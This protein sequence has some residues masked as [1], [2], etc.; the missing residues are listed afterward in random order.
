MA[1]LQHRVAWAL[2]CLANAM[3]HLH[4][5]PETAERWNDRVYQGMVSPRGRTAREPGE[6]GGGAAN[7]ARRRLRPITLKQMSSLNNAPSTGSSIV[8]I[9]GQMLGADDNSARV[10]LGDTACESTTWISLTSLECVTPSGVWRPGTKSAVVVSLAA[11]L[12]AGP[13]GGCEHAFPATMRSRISSI[14]AHNHTSF[15]LSNVGVATAQTIAVFGAGYSDADYSPALKMAHSACQRTEWATSSAII[16]KTT[17]GVGGT[18]RVVLTAGMALGTLTEALSYSTPQLLGNAYETRTFRGFDRYNPALLPGAACSDGSAEAAFADGV[19]GCDG[20]WGASE[21][22][23]AA[24]GR[25]LCSAGFELCAS[26]DVVAALGVEAGGCGAAGNGT[27]YVTGQYS[28]DGLSCGAVGGGAGMRGGG[29][30]GV[31]AWGCG[32]DGNDGSGAGPVAWQSEACGVLS[33]SVF[34]GSNVSGGGAG[35]WNLTGAS[36]RSIS[37]GEGNGGVMCAGYIMYTL[38][39][40]QAR[41]NAPAS[42]AERFVCVQHDAALGWV[43]LGDSGAAP[44]QL[45]PTDLLVASVDYDLDKVTLLQTTTRGAPVHGV[46]A[47]YLRGDLEVE[48]GVFGGASDSGEFEV[49]GTSLAVSPDALDLS[50]LP[51]ALGALHAWYTVASFRQAEGAWLDASGNDMHAQLAGLVS[52]RLVEGHGAGGGVRAVGGGQL[53]SVTFPN[54]SLPAGNFTM[55][56]VARYADPDPAT[57]GSVI[58]AAES[59]W[60]LGH[61]LG[62]AGLASVGG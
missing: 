37:K 25:A 21:G 22:G 54:G 6:G 13:G 27:F 31:G 49:H 35:A 48:P 50:T 52:E 30:G 44:F 38:T 16:C 43:H 40:A 45:E 57:Q 7:G 17:G 47:G 61:H 62:R 12:V 34:A 20:A 9:L 51:T 24:A 3:A 42:N 15:A 1:R 18:H 41:F 55:C 11:R 46:A 4:P 32:V 59:E 23:L 28:Q 29:G 33:G 53:T 56:A 5:P 2:L 26:S 19:V 60:Y 36:A 10:R 8:T 39:S 58:A 14:A